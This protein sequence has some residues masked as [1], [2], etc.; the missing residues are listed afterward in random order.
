MAHAAVLLPTAALRVAG[1][2]ACSR[3][4]HR[5]SLVSVLD[6]RLEVVV[7]YTVALV[8]TAKAEIARRVM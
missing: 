6:R 4:S 5:R 3:M 8:S 7:S 2:P 1:S